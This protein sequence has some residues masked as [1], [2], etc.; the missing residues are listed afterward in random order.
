MTIR[1]NRNRLWG[2]L[3]LLLAAFVVLNQLGL[4]IALSFGS[5]VA[6][7]LAVV[8]LINCI[9]QR[10]ITTLPFVIAMVYIVLRNQEL[11]A[12]VS[13][14]AVLLAAVL[15]SA[16]IGFLFPQRP[17]GKVVV[18]TFFGGDGW[19]EWDEDG[20]NPHRSRSHTATIG[21]DNNPSINVIFGSESRYLHADALETAHL[22]CNFGGMEIFFDQ[23]QISPNGATVYLD[24]KFG[25]IDLYVPRHWNVVEQVNCVFGGTER[26]RRLEEP[27][28]DAPILTITG[29]VLFGGVDIKYI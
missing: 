16:G 1:N 7:V 8:F 26:S 27:A 22:T 11:V 9:T 13:T 2:V 29:N 15:V 14:W 3:F 21:M 20:E 23:A 19:D 10:R 5:L 28:K 24:C 12:H 18:G 6:M 17:R 25:G 4:F